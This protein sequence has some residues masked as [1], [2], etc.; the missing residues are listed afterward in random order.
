MAK[1][2]IFILSIALAAHSFGQ[3]K[4]DKFEKYECLSGFDADYKFNESRASS[5]AVGITIFDKKVDGDKLE[6][7]VG[8]YGNCGD[9]ENIDIRVLG[10]TIELVYG[11]NFREYTEDDGTI[12]HEIEVYLCDCCLNFKYFL[13]GLDP[14]IN[15]VIKLTYKVINDYYGTP[16]DVVNNK[17]RSIYYSPQDD[18]EELFIEKRNK[19]IEDYK[20]LFKLYS[21]FKVDRSSKKWDLITQKINK[22]WSRFLYTTKSLKDPFVLEQLGTKRYSELMKPFNDLI[23]KLTPKLQHEYERI[24]N[25]RIWPNWMGDEPIINEPELTEEERN[26]LLSSDVV[27]IITEDPPELLISMDS[28]NQFID[29]KIQQDGK[30]KD[31]EGRIYVEY[32][33]GKDGSVLEKNIV[34]G[35]EKDIDKFVSA[36][37]H[38]LDFS[39]SPAKMRGIAVKSKVIFP[40][41]IKAPTSSG[42][43]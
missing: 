4:L 18:I 42:E 24:K 2:L 26:E 39:F 36:R 25:N 5:H 29:D 12:S 22:T 13:S 37:L 10:D 15:Y 6:M 27:Y 35:I 40:V 28:I 38:E 17:D 33:I 19:A 32:I 31:T 41:T 7:F 20:L 30:F 34:K 21:R 23:M 8:F 11:P 1:I 14:K 3:I 9:A 16:I 43:N